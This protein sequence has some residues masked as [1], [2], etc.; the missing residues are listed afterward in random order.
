MTHHHVKVPIP[1][2]STELIGKWRVTCQRQ[3]LRF[4]SQWAALTREETRTMVTTAAPYRTQPYATTLTC[5]EHCRT[6]LHST[7]LPSNHPQ[8]PTT[9]VLGGIS[10]NEHPVSH[11]GR[12]GAGWWE[13]TLG[14]GQGIDPAQHNLLSFRWLGYDGDIDA[15]I[16]TTDQATALAQILKSHQITGP[17]QF[18]AAS[19]GAMVAAQFAAQ[20]PQ[21]VQR[22]LLIGGGPNPH[23]YGQAYRHLQRQ[24]LAELGSD[25]A[26]ALALVRQLAMLS[27]RSPKDL[28]NKAH[29]AQTW[30]ANQGQEF[31]DRFHPV[32]YQR[33]SESID[34]HHVDP[35]HITVPTTV[36]GITEDLIAPPAWLADFAAALPQGRYLHLESDYGHDGF[37]K[38][39]ARLGR[40]MRTA[41]TA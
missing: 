27:Y 9:I 10:A 4:N 28:A 18:V 5:G 8:A 16:T 19:Y 36:V 1:A 41:W 17:V 15:P 30:L 25:S 12:S 26:T 2:I 40:V 39:P 37:L 29:F 14:P 3:A 24:I 35:A 21:Q 31:I 22:L 38:E 20:Y 23:P 7:W 32:A 13:P 11:A 6:T 34:T 33:L